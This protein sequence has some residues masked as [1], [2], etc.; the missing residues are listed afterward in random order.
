MMVNTTSGLVLG[1][2][3]QILHL[4]ACGRKVLNDS[5]ASPILS[6]QYAGLEIAGSKLSTIL[7]KPCVRQI[8]YWPRLS[9]LW[10]RSSYATYA[11]VKKESIFCTKKDNQ[12]SNGGMIARLATDAVSKCLEESHGMAVSYAWHNTHD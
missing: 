7:T 10:H 2:S 11:T 12:L 1:K 3:T 5:P 9:A 6:L 4:M 8:G